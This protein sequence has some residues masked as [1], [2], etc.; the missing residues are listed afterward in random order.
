MRGEQDRL[1]MM[2]EVDVD[3]LDTTEW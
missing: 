1:M 2:P 3:E